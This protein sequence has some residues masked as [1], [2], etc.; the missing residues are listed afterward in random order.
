MTGTPSKDRAEGWRYEICYGPEGETN[1]AFVYDAEGTLVSNLKLYHAI[2]VVDAMNGKGHAT[3]F[4][5]GMKRAA[6]I[7]N[8]TR[9]G[10]VEWSDDGHPIA[11]VVVG[12]RAIVEAILSE[13]REAK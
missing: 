9:S 12:G 3:G 4:V 2:A 8:K 7:A 6:E 13:L 5:E 11:S 10:P 1:Y